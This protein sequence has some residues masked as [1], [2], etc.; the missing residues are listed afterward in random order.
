M[1]RLPPIRYLARQAEPTRISPFFFAVSLLLVLIV[2]LFPFSNWRFT[3]EP[4]FAFFSYPFPYYMTVFDNAVNVL[5]YIPLG[6]GLVLMFRNR[7]LAAIFAVIGCALI[8]SS[9]EFTQQFLPGRIASNV[10]ILSNTTGGAIGVMIGLVLRSRRWMQRWFIFRHELLAPG[11]MMEWGLVW[12][13]L[14]FVAQL[15]PTQPFLGVV[16]EA[17]GLP[18]PFVTPIADAGLFLRVLESSG[19]ML[20]LAGVGLFVSVLLAYGRDIPRAIALVLSLAL[21]LKMTFA[22]MLLKPEQFFAW[23]NL[24]I[25]LGGLC[26]ALLLAISWKLQRRYRAF[27]GVVCLS[28][29]TVIS[30]VWPLSPQ[31]VA[32]LPLFKWQYGHLLHFSGLAQI[33]GDIWP[34]GAILL[35]LWY[36]LGRVT[37]D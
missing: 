29:A 25:V 22:G 14:W 28:L 26:G 24:N 31:L 21:L 30:L 3:G 27:L 2:S 6:L 23:L 36:L 8:S 1:P 33:V 34:F 12:L 19:M 35:L 10:D 4:V 20:N 9:I 13:V 11:R 16:V 7:W 32:T 15:D 37:T 17:R 5:A 18:Q